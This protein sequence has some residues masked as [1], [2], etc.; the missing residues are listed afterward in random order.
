V[1]VAA[2]ERRPNGAREEHTNGAALFYDLRLECAVLGSMIVYPDLIL[3][4]KVSAQDFHGEANAT[5]FGALYGL[6]S[7]GAEVGTAELIEALQQAGRLQAVGGADYVDG[8][9]DNT[10]PIRAV[11]TRRLRRLALE[12]RENDL[13]RRAFKATGQTRARYRRELEEVRTA[14]AALGHDVDVDATDPLSGLDRLSKVLVRSRVAL[15][16]LARIAPEYVWQDIAVAGTILLIAG[17]PGEGK[18]TLLFLVL[19]AR[20]NLGGPVKLLDR[21]VMPA[22]HGKFIVLIEGEHS[23]AS[24]A[25]K[26][27]RSMA[28]L[29]VEESALD[30][31]FVIA[32]KQVVIGSPE[33]SEI[34]EL[35]KRGYVSDIAIDTIARCA[36]ADANDER[37]QVKVFD[38]LAA[39]I[40]LAPAGTERPIVWVIAHTRKSGNGELSDVSGSTQRVGQADT[41]LLVKGNRVDGRVAS[42][43]VTFAKLREDPDEYPAT[44]DFSI[45][46][47]EHGRPR[48][49]AGSAAADDERPLTVRI[50]ELLAER[51]PLTKYAIRDHLRRNAKHV[52]AAVRTLF[53]ERRLRTD[54]ERIRGQDRQVISLAPE[55]LISPDVSPDSRF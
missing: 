52:D 14:V 36:P 43:R 9:I 53:K 3:A 7:H 41:V 54:Y 4:S 18:T 25:R 8:L 20:A 15:M 11:D 37:E 12:R 10:V 45:G 22:P 55:R 33:W 51:G 50:V 39:L 32:R 6:A 24:T 29:G 16:A 40:D 19:A 2:N 31:V 5:V 44:I 49:T 34:G 21:P 17:G 38:E 27:V 48:L 13:F 35:V 28:L 42:S 46:R 26:L 47:D 23:E 1:V 30:R